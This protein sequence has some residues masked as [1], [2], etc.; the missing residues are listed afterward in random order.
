MLASLLIALLWVYCQLYILLR[1]K[2]TVLDEEMSR[3][4]T[5]R[6]AAAP[7]RYWDY[8]LT[9][10]VAG[11]MTAIGGLFCLLPGVV[12]AVYFALWPACA[13]LGG[14]G[15]AS[16]LFYSLLGFAAVVMFF[17]YRLVPATRAGVQAGSG[18]GAVTT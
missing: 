8:V 6:Q 17:N 10:I 13:V 16:V 15:I 1:M 12:L 11:V 2:Q 18:E 9:G 5:L 7:R 14:G 3:T 4:E